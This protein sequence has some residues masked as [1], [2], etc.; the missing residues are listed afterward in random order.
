MNY[1][2]PTKERFWRITCATL[3]SLVF[4]L[5]VLIL[6]RLLQL[7]LHRNKKDFITTAIVLSPLMFISGFM[8]WRF[9]TGL[10]SSNGKTNLPSWF[11]GL[12]GIIFLSLL[13][14]IGYFHPEQLPAILIPYGFI[15]YYFY[16]SRRDKEPKSNSSLSSENQSDQ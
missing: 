8:A 7:D 12:L 15:A 9:W 11:L 3:M 1:Q 13:G 6:A 5:F 16:K 14:L 10:I 4:L 2:E